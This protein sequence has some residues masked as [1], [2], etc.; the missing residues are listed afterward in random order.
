VSDVIQTAFQLK[1]K[2]PIFLIVDEFS[3]F[4][5]PDFSFILDQARKVNLKCILAHQHLAQVKEED[6]QVFSAALTNTSHKLVMGGLSNADLEILAGELFIDEWDFDERK[7]EIQRTYFHPHESRRTIQGYSHGSGASRS[8]SR[9]STFG[10]NEELWG[11]EQE[12]RGTYEAS[13]ESESE[14]ESH[15][16]IEVPFY[17]LEEKQELSSVQFRSP[18]ELKLRSM[19]KLKTLKKREFALKADNQRVKFDRTLEVPDI[20]LLERL[21]DQALTE[22]FQNQP[23]YASLEEISL[24][25]QARLKALEIQSREEQDDLYPEQWSNP[26]PS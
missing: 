19:V 24:E 1:L 15:S 7:L 4:V 21:K 25:E 16:E 13:G 18:E 22:V 17:E 8:S 9:G 11:L 2:R 26:E 6:P 3:Q 5:T 10:A 23:Y 12:L 14:F 20:E